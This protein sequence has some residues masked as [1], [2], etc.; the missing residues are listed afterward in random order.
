MKLKDQTTIVTGGGRGI[1]RA[2]GERF[3]KEGAAVFLTSRTEDELRQVSDGISKAGGKA[4]FLAA[5]VSQ[6]ADVE[7]VVAAARKEFGQID[8]LVNNAGILGPMKPIAETSTEEWD[9][10]MAVNLRSA[11]LLTRAVLPE[12][13]ERKR[14]VILNISTTAAKMAHAL[15]S[16]YAS[17]KAGMLALTRV[18]ASEAGRSGVRVNSICPGPVDG[19]KMWAEVSEG[20]QREFKISHEEFTQQAYNMTQLGRPLSPEEIAAAA[21]FLCSDEAGSITGQSIN[22]DAGS[23]VFY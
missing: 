23:M 19:T 13:M 1:G 6:E 21:L 2:I 10:V 16:T 22:A 17:S 20:V 15:S 4:A 12:M 11:F 14:G 3:A 9:R 7:K 5:D 8:I 18:A